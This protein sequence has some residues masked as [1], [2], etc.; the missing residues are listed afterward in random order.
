MEYG[1]QRDEPSGR[2]RW[3]REGEYRGRVKSTQ[4]EINRK[5]AVEQF[6]R[7][8]YCRYVLAGPAL[9]KFHCVLGVTAGNGGNRREK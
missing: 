3:D 4:V 8:F 7:Y 2:G 9:I 6:A 5:V 1:T